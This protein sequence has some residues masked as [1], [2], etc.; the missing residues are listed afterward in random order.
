MAL[1]H[2]FEYLNLIEICVIV[3]PCVYLSTYCHSLASHQIMTLA[4]LVCIFHYCPL[5]LTSCESSGYFAREEGNLS[6]AALPHNGV[7][8]HHHHHG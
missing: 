3:L 8:V 4:N 6:G 7:I 1:V 5:L 2:T